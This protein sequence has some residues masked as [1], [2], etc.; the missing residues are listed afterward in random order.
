MN[1][2]INIFGDRFVKGVLI[3]KVRPT[4]IEEQNSDCFLQHLDFL[5]FTFIS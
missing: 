5:K 3:Y 1:R 2:N 4:G